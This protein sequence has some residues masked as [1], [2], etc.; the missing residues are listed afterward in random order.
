MRHICYTSYG[1]AIDLNVFYSI[2][3][4]ANRKNAALGIGG[5][6]S[7]HDQSLTQIL[8]GPEEALA[9]LM[10]AIWR[11]ERHDGIVI[12]SDFSIET[13]H[14]RNFGMA[15][16][17]PLDLARHSIAIS[18]AHRQPRR[19]AEEARYVRALMRSMPPQGPRGVGHKTGA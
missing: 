10:D 17:H 7:F 6:I 14:F 16:V 8:E 19:D 2:V 1:K 5:E 3:D 15:L 11:D 18:A 4:H 9:T 12:I 13:T